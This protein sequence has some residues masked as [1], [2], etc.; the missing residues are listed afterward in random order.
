MAHIES[1]LRERLGG[2]RPTQLE[3][4]DESHLHA[5]HPVQGGSANFRLLITSPDFVGKTPLQA[6]RMVYSAAG[7]LMQVAIH[8]LSITTRCP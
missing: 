5:G 6:Q 1:I 8:S 7:D 4:V 2:L 3:I